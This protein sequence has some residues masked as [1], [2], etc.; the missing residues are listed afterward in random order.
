VPVLLDARASEIHIACE[1]LSAQAID[2]A[3]CPIFI[4]LDDRFSVRLLIDARDERVQRE[5][6]LPWNRHRFFDERSESAAFIRS[7]MVHGDSVHSVHEF[8]AS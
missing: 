3:Q 6:I 2:C 1:A 4:D 8:E 7:K 5:G